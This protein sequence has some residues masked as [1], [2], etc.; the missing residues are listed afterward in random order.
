LFFFLVTNDRPCTP[1]IAEDVPLLLRSGDPNGSN[2]WAI[3]PS[4]SVGGHTLLL[5]N[6]HLPWGDVFT[7]SEAQLSAPGYDTYGA[8]LVGWP[9]PVIAFNDALGWTHTVNTHD[10]CDAYA[11]VRDGDGYRYDGAHRAFETRTVTLR[12]RRGDGGFD[13]VPFVVRRAAQGPVVTSGEKDL[14]IRAVGF[15]GSN[16]DGA[17][18]EW[19]DL[20]RAHDLA[21]FRAVLARLQIPMFNA[22]YA[23]RAG[24][25]MLG[26]N[27]QVPVHR[28]GDFATWSHPVAGDTSSNVWTQLEPASALPSVVDPPGGWVQNANSPPWTTS[29]PRTLDAAHFPADLAPAAGVRYRELSAIRLLSAPGAFD[30]DRLVE[31]KFSDRAELADR[32][33]DDLVAAA[34]TDADPQVRAAAAVLE[35]WDRT[36]GAQSRGAA[37]FFAW[38][39]EMKLDGT[40]GQD[41]LAVPFDPAN[42]SGSARGLKDKA[43]AVAALG[44]AAAR[45]QTEC[46]A[47]DAPW[48]TCFRLRRGA[49]DLPARTAPETMGI[50]AATAFRPARDGH[51]ASFGGDSFIAAVDFGPTVRARVLLPYGNASQPGSPHIGDQLALYARGAMRDAWRTPTEIDAHLEARETLDQ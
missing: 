32:V 22:V 10:G 6:P 38:T 20:G 4:R 30:L 37:L 51:F 18:A 24:H 26:F 27:G 14:A 17:L 46:G 45:A 3:G 13:T 40:T 42:P 5:A 33:L 43:A 2:A 23:D 12:A 48:G 29:Y 25:V 19:Y 50:V 39:R 7:W 28:S 36:T 34:R 1:A 11:L 31:A 44:R 9:V 21:R 49:V 15:D 41:V 16:F 8:A 35:R 47:L